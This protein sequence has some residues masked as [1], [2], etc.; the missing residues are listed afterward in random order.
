MQH[1][2]ISARTKA[3][4]YKANYC[5]YGS[6]TTAAVRPTPELPFPVVYTPRGAK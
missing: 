2:P 6:R 1:T 4:A 3:P 5:V